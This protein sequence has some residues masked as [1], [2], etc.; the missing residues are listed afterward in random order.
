MA[1]FIPLLI[2]MLLFPLYQIGENGE[3]AQGWLI[4]YAMGIILW[5]IIGSYTFHNK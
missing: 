1:N 4:A 5:I 2:W 3:S